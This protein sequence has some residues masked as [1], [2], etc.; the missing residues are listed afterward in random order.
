MTEF[1]ELLLEA[2]KSHNGIPQSIIS[3][4]KE[5]ILLKQ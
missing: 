4:R 2:Q 3:E 1:W 5:E